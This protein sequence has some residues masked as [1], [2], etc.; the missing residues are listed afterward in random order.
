MS[1][2]N[3]QSNKSDATSA[4]S[5]LNVNNLEYALPTSIAACSARQWITNAFSSASANESDTIQC[6]VMSGRYLF[7]GRTSYFK[8]Q[9]VATVT[10]HARF[11]QGS[12]TNLIEQMAVQ[13][14]SG[15][16]CGRDSGI[17]ALHEIVDLYGG[18]DEWNFN[19]GGVQGFLGTS[20]VKPYTG[21]SL[22]VKRWYAIPLYKLM[23]MFDRETLIPSQVLAGSTVSV[24]F[25]TLALSVLASGSVAS[26]LTITTP[27]L[28]L[29]C[30]TPIDLVQN[31]IN[32]IASTTGLEYYYD[33]W[34]HSQH[35]VGAVTDINLNSNVKLAQVSAVVA[36]LRDNS[37]LDGTDGDDPTVS[38]LDTGVPALASFQV[39]V[40]GQYVQNSPVNNHVEMYYSALNA[41]DKLGRQTGCAVSYASFLTSHSVIACSLARSNVLT[42]SG[43]PLDIGQA[44]NI[45]GTTSNAVARRADMFIKYSA[46]LKIF[47]DRILPRK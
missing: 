8:F 3:G 34:Y 37:R 39:N 23:G 16:E 25:S 4:K 21:D 22:K 17:G 15:T 19:Q 1:V 13:S 10:T 40:G 45:T 31:S 5:I 47:S 26:A 35:S 2:M 14:A 33:S 38:S 18:S 44:L 9:A 43:V 7:D 12:A 6:N 36:R 46:M 32:K 11:S 41:F 28:V 27:S 24:T 20:G 29:D 30:Y 42:R